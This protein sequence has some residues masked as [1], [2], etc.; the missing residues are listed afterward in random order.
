MH[1]ILANLVAAA[2]LY[3]LSQARTLLLWL[4]R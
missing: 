3:T 1:V 2:D 4:P